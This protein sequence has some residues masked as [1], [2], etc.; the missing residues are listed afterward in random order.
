MLR[1]NITDSQ[2]TL[3]GNTT[4][5]ETDLSLNGTL[6]AEWVG[7]K[8]LAELPSKPDALQKLLKEG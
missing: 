6:R 7:D 1:I 5:D 4:L 2:G 3:L 8:I